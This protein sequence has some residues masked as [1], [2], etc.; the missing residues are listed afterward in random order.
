MG[1]PKL[2]IVYLKKFDSGLKC[3]AFFL[4]ILILSPDVVLAHF[5][6]LFMKDSH[7]PQKIHK[8]QGSRNNIQCSALTCTM[9]GYLVLIQADSIPP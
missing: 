8:T 4:H 6:I 1:S 2:D 5:V 9:W 3:M 7:P